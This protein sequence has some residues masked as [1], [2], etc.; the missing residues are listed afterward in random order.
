MAL[1]RDRLVPVKK[2]RKLIGKI[3][4]EPTLDKVHD[5]RTLTRKFEAIFEALSL[6]TLIS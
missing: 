2:L 1:D 5:L 3:D 6:N 4:Q